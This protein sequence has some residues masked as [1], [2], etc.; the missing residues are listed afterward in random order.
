VNSL[1]FSPSFI[2]IAEETGRELLEPGLLNGLLNMTSRRLVAVR[3]LPEKL[4][5]THGRGF[6]RE[7]EPYL[8]AD[9]P[10]VVL[11]CSRLRHLDSAGIHVLLRVLEEA[12]KRNGDVKLASVPPGA[13]AM[14][15]LTRVG[16]LF[17]VFDNTAD[18][19]NSFHQIPMRPVPNDLSHASSPLTARV[20]NHSSDV[21]QADSRK[22]SADSEAAMTA[23][24]RWVRRQ[25]AGCLVLLLIAPLAAAGTQ[26]E[27][28]SSRHTDVS[29]SAQSQDSGSGVSKANDEPLDPQ[30][31]PNSPGASRSLT[32]DSNQPSSVQ[33]PSPN[34]PQ[35]DTQRPVGTAAAEFIKTTGVAASK[36]AGSA[37]APAKQRR[38]RS[39]LIKVGAIV[40]AGVAVGAVVALSAA[41]PSRP[42]GAH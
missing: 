30:A 14:L 5:L 2:A 1:E 7:V 40:G 19:V 38:A 20:R 39:I 4:S 25:I 28:S 36:P 35:S 42:S 26:Q 9:R 34:Q 10:R 27:T 18:A 23:S 8:Q 24:R 11:D 31:L 22:R 12:M 29:P 15:G 33:Q 21:V 6:F 16:R 41:S 17:E 37:I 3:H 32:A 13:A